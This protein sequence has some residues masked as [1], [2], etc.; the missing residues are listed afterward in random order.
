MFLDPN[1][2]SMAHI[3]FPSSLKDEPQCCLAPAKFPVSRLTTMTKVGEMIMLGCEISHHVFFFS[4]CRYKSTGL[5]IPTCSSDFG[6]VEWGI[7]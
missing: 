1:G 2:S 4:K 5:S 3:L 6:A 7:N